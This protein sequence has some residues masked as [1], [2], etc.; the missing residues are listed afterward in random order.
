MIKLWTT[1]DHH[2]GHSV[3]LTDNIRQQTKRGTGSEQRRQLWTKFNF[4][5][6]VCFSGEGSTFTA[7]HALQRTVESIFSKSYE[8]LSIFER[9]LLLVGK[10]K[11]KQQVSFWYGVQ[12]KF[13]PKVVSCH[14]FS[15]WILEVRGSWKEQDRQ[16]KIVFLCSVLFKVVN[17]FSLTAHYL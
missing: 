8:K 1:W 10:Y 2:K 14:S 17:L 16:R 12:P 13:D 5:M 3:S 4:A 7:Y 11:N 15:C 9:W 6:R